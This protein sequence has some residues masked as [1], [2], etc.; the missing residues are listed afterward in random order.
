[1]I[2]L[3]SPSAVVARLHID[4]PLLFGL[5]VLALIGL[6]VLYSASV[7]NDSPVIRQLI[8]IGLAFGVMLLVAQVAPVYLMYW[9]PWLYVIGLLFLIG[10]LVFTMSPV[11]PS[12]CQPAAP[13]TRRRAQHRCA[14]PR[15]RP[16]R[17]R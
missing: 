2:G 11:Q 15:P 7:Q 3:P 1:M 14:C 17:C 8:R 5:L 16:C 4:W 13:A 12:N 10:V 9:A 6:T